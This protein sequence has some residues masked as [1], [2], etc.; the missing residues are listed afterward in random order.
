MD[1]VIVHVHNT[2]EVFSL[3]GKARI[4]QV[5]KFFECIYNCIHSFSDDLLKA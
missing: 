4:N 3:V 2:F 5:S 1:A